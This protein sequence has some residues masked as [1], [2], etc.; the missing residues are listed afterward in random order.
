MKITCGLVVYNEEKQIERCL[1]SV[2][3]FADEI[4][5]IHDG[6]CHDKTIE[7][8]KKYTNKIYIREH[9]GGSDPHRLEILRKATNNWVFMLD[10]DEFVPSDLANEILSESFF[11]G[12]CGAIALRWPI[13]NGIRE[14]TRHNF[15]PC[16][17]NK[18]KCWAIGLHNF[19]IQTELLICKKDLILGHRPKQSKFGLNLNDQVIKKR[20]LRDAHQFLLGYQNLDK[21]NEKLIPL[22]FQVKFERYLRHAYWYAYINLLKHFAGSYKQMYRDGWAGFLTSL[23]LGLY[24][25]RLAKTICHLKKISH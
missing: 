4:I 17:F 25:Y 13:W 10:A 12:D 18:E 23:Q 5:I 19:S 9:V 6:D 24:Q 21:Y 20:I 15:R 16:I 11:L 7:I 22:F 3:S 1:S 8:A 14:V 2:V